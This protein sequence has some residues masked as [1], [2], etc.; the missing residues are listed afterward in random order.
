MVVN[1]LI[2][3]GFSVILLESSTLGSGQTG[4]SQGIIHGGMKYALR[5]KMTASAK[6]MADMPNF[7]NCC[8]QGHGEID[9]SWSRILSPKQYL[10]STSSL[11][12]RLAGLVA[13]V[14]FKNK[15]RFLK[16]HEFP[17]IFQHPNFI[18][19]VNEL[20]EMVIDVYALLQALSRPC[21]HAI[22]KIII[23]TVH[24]I[25]QTNYSLYNSS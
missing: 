13:N 23:C 22:F 5:G 7:W 25:H 12:S 14:S 21:F 6:A 1:R 15:I 3:L 4:K 9:L 24:L 2:T 11:G 20:D 8:L 19:Q 18:G 16:K 10:W 17:V